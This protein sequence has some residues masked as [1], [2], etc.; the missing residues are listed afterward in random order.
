MLYITTH[1]VLSLCSIRIKKYLLSSI[2]VGHASGELI[3]NRAAPTFRTRADCQL[4]SHKY[5]E[6]LLNNW[7]SVLTS[8]TDIWPI[9][10]SWQQKLV[11]EIA[12][13]HTLKSRGCIVY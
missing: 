2:E 5:T 4:V 6:R 1:A 8:T 13:V 11:Q 3:E 7:I 9:A 12:V 10:E